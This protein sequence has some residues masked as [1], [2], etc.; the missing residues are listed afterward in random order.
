M[1]KDALNMQGYVEVFVTSG[2]TAPS[3]F[4][5]SMP[6]RMAEDPEAARAWVELEGGKLFDCFGGKNIIVDTGK[7]KVIEALVAGSINQI[8]RMAIGD[9][10][11]LPSDSTVPKVPTG[12]M[13]ALF[14]E[15]YRKNIDA[16]TL[17]IGT[18]G[19]HEVK[20]TASFD[21]VD[22]PISSFSN[23]TQPVVNEV[24]LVTF[25][26]GVADLSTRGPVASPNTPSADEKMFSMRTF[27]SVP[28]E[29]SNEISVT[30]RYTIFID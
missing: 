16:S 18:P 15:V 30:I 28:F 9:R 8:G 12:T 3:Q 10:G 22:V 6:S 2:L 29:A 5:N 4:I 25:D 27:K 26:Q 7:D 24:A 21:A 13:T 14:N 23:Q 20:F 19:V 1:Q 17:N 11:T